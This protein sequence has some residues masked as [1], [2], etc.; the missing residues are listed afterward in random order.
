MKQ[1]SRT[2]EAGLNLL[3]FKSFTA[4]FLVIVGPRLTL[5]EKWFVRSIDSKTCGRY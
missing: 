5:E 1:C 4:I 2:L 3:L